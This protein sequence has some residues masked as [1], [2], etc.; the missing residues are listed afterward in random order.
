MFLPVS[1]SG[2]NIMYFLN[3]GHVI[4]V[5]KVYSLLAELHTKESIA[6][7]IKNMGCHKGSTI[8]LYTMRITVTTAKASANQYLN[9]FKSTQGNRGH[10]SGEWVLLN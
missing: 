4:C 6:L 9:Q 5:L 8:T 2:K 7:H 1:F 10:C 3:G